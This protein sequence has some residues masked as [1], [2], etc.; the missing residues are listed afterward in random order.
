MQKRH[1]DKIGTQTCNDICIYVAIIYLC[2][3]LVS[4]LQSLYF[5]TKLLVLLGWLGRGS[6]FT[7]PQCSTFTLLFLFLPLSLQTPPYSVPLEIAATHGHTQ[8]VERLLEGGALINYQR[9]VCNIMTG[10]TCYLY[11]SLVYVLIWYECMN[12]E[13]PSSL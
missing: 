5:L 3:N 2:P 9:P 10:I 7:L 13:W 8:C 4:I 11:S 12:V 6:I 1:Q